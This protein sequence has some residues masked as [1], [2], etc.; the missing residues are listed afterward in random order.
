MKKIYSIKERVIYTPLITALG[1]IIAL[2]LNH[3]NNTA[4]LYI[5]CACI[6]VAVLLLLKLFQFPYHIVINKDKMKIYDFPLL[7]T[8]RF[9]RE[10]RSLILWNSEIFIDEVKSVELVKLSKEQKMKFIGYVHF[11]NKY[12]KVSLNNSNGEKYI[13]ASIYSKSQIKKIVTLL[14]MPFQ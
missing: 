6:V 14:V 7:A 1:V 12:I 10:K 9:Y 2:L 11:F 13:Y 8:N 5:V 3:S 4:I